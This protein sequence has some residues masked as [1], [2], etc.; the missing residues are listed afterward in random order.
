[1]P[2]DGSSNSEFSGGSAVQAGP[3]DLGESDFVSGGEPQDQLQATQSY[4]QEVQPQSQAET[5]QSLA[6]AVASLGYD[7]GDQRPADDWTALSQITAYAQ[8]ARMLEQQARDS[9]V[10]SDIGRQLAPQADRIRE[11]IQQ[12]QAPAG[13]KP[14][15]APPFD[16]RWASLVTQDPGTGLYVGKPGTPPGIVDAANKFADYNREY[17]RNPVKLI[18]QVL[19]D[20]QSTV[21]ERISAAVEARIQQYQ[22]QQE[23]RAIV[24]QNANWAYAKDEQGNFRTDATGNYLPSP[25]GSQYV[26]MVQTLAKAGVADPKMRDQFAKGLLQAQIAAVSNQPAPNQQAAQARQKAAMQQQQVRRNPLQ[27]LPANERRDT[28][29][30]TEPPSGISMRDALD[31]DF[32]QA[33]I[34]DDFWKNSSFGL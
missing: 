2:P 30:A 18:N 34:T 27:G 14:Y 28:L 11:Y 8:R 3:G 9:Q 5:A 1:M 26:A 19:Q 24:Q 32:Q 15:E 29:H 22:Q 25:V 13:P 33:G 7:W 6:D 16:E 4:A 12:Q 10:Y 31:R 17:A 23:V 20:H 21:D